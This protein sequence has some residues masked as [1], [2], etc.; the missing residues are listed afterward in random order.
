MS[1]PDKDR[2]PYFKGKTF[3]IEDETRYQTSKLGSLGGFPTVA[4]FTPEAASTPSP[5]AP[6]SNSPEINQAK[7]RVKS[8]EDDVLSGKVSNDIYGKG[9]QLGQSQQTSFTKSS[10]DKSDDYKLD[11]NTSQTDAQNQLQNYISKYSK[12]KSNN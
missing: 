1:R 9:T 10:N 7:D 12:Y 2:L 8:Y 3:G 6:I 11:L 5:A 4:P